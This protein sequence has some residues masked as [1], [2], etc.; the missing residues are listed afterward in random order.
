[1]TAT[2]LPAGI[3]SHAPFFETFILLW[4]ES[5][6]FADRVLHKGILQHF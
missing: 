1:M 6:N 4:S 2:P 3:V 5:R